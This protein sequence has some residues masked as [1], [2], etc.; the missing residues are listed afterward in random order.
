MTFELLRDLFDMCMDWDLGEWRA[1]YFRCLGRLEF[2]LKKYNKVMTPGDGRDSVQDAWEEC[3][4][5]C[6]YLLKCHKEGRGDK[7]RY[8][9]EET[10]NTLAHL[11]GELYGR[12][13]ISPKD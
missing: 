4:D 10:M 7:F 12:G 3:F 5:L 6:V 2:G 13:T 11:E 8:L 1:F 9:Y